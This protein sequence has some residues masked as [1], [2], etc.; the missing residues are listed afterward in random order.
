MALGATLAA[1]LTL[2]VAATASAADPTALELRAPQEGQLRDTIPIT[3][4]LKDGKGSP[5]PRAPVILWS[6]ASFLGTGGALRL[7]QSITDAQGKAIFHYEPRSQGPVTLN[8]YFPGDSR[9]E[10]VQASVELRVQG[11]AQL[12]QQTAGI[13]VPGVGVWMLVALMIG[14]WSVYLTVMVLL[15]RVA[16]AGLDG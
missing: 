10:P 2:W 12:Y 16:R 8:A 5:I 15:R 11:A 13:H 1:L 4:V 6:P 14:V 7:G 9:Y 3:A